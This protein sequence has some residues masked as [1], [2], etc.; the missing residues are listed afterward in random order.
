MICELYFNKAVTHIHTHIYAHTHTV[1][2]RDEA[3][4][5]RNVLLEKVVRECLEQK[6]T[7]EQR[8]KEGEKGVLQTSRTEIQQSA[9]IP[10]LCIHPKSHYPAPNLPG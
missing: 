7:L 5:G 4:R 6:R 9:Q 3:Q 10:S 8:P 2:E 1:L